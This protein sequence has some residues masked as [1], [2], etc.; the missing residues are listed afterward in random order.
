MQS[1]QER[2]RYLDDKDYMNHRYD[3][4]GVDVILFSTLAFGLFS[5]L[6]ERWSK[7]VE[8]NTDLVENFDEGE[9]ANGFDPK[10][11]W[12]GGAIKDVS[13]SGEFNEEEME[14]PF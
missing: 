8:Q 5:A 6:A 14:V 12:H 9:K 10:K 7:P 1:Y 13:G 4:R 11:P 2:R 3:G